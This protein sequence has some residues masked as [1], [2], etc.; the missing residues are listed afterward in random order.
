MYNLKDLLAEYK[1]QTH[2]TNDYI[3]EQCGVNK[4]T[5]SRWCRGHTKK[6]SSSTL[7]KLA[8]LLQLD[9]D[10]LSSSSFAGLQFEKPIL[11]TVKAGYGLFAEQ[12]LDGY[13]GVSQEDYNSGDY[14]LRVSGDSMIGEKIHDQDLLY[15]KAVDDV[16]SGTIAV[17]LIGGDEVSVKKLIKKKDYWILQAANPNVEPRIFTLQEVEETPVRVIGKVLYARSEI[18]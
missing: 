11:G 18:A 8:N 16:P 9:P 2:Q 15:V 7:E 6:I 3:A 5:V 10:D 17:V 12:N 1:R 14:F 13:V 4:S